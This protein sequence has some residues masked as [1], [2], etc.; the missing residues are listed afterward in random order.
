MT[1]SRQGSGNASSKEDEVPLPAILQPHTEGVLHEATGEAR[2]R[3]SKVLPTI[4]DCCIAQQRQLE[5]TA[6]QSRAEL[7][8]ALPWMLKPEVKESIE[9]H[10]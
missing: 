2:G 7:A 1:S 8:A 3:V 4:S 5:A 6:S 9:A 10:V